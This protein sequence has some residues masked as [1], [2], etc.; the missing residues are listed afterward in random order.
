[1][2][3]SHFRRLALAALVSGAGLSLSAPRAAFGAKY[4]LNE[5]LALARKQNPGIRAGAAATHAMQAQ[6]TE[7]R[8]NWY[9]QGDF[10]SFVAPVPRVECEGVNQTPIMGDQ[11]VREGNCITTN[12]SPSHGALT[13]LT[14]FAGAWSR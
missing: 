14:Q 9:P 11:S 1:M 8:R 10:T 6:V 13:Y 12:A 4:T 2:K 3:E 5:L 7:A